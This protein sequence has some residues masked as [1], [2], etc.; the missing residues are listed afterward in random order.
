MRR[1][2]EYWC[3]G[4]KFTW[5]EEKAGENLRKH[6]VSFETACW[7]V[8][9]DINVAEEQEEEDG[10]R[11]TAIISFPRS[12]ESSALLFVVVTDAEDSLRIISAR[13]A[14]A[15]EKR[16]YEKENSSY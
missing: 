11:R 8:L 13:K 15:A 7:A 6:G 2:V 12:V 5:D 4:Y 16:R 9:N 14:V 3:G 10:D 1:T